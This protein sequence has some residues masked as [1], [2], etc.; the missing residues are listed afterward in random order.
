MAEQCPDPKHEFK[1]LFSST[2]RGAHLAR[3][4][5]TQR[6]AEWGYVTDIAA[7]IVSEL[8]ANAA[9]HCLAAHRD[10]LLRLAV[11]AHSPALLRI[12]VSDACGEARPK[13]RH[14]T[15]DAESGRGLLLVGAMAIAWGVG[16]RTPGKTV[17]AQVLLEP[18]ADLDQGRREPGLT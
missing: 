17:W 2:S 6:L 5:A 8:A 18:A 12:E 11:H 10:F 14:P 9:T 13:P 4:S 3:V 7:L 1:E 16:E 15:G